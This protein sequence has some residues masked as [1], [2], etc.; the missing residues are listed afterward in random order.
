MESDKKDLVK[1]MED[2]RDDATKPFANAEKSSAA[3]INRGDDRSGNYNNGKNP[4]TEGPDFDKKS[5]N[6]DG[7]T[8]ENAGIFK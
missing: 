3:E 6:S 2:E 5:K 8:S 1:K 7:D 4:E